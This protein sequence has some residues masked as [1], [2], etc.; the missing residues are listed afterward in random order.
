MPLRTRARTAHHPALVVKVAQDHKQTTVF[1]AEHVL[2]RNLDVVEG[3]EAGTGG[4][5]VGS[6]DRLGLDTFTTGNEEDCESAF[7]FAADGEVAE[8]NDMLD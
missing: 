3:D 6:L 4:G 8:G 2:R 5:R 7:G 1:G